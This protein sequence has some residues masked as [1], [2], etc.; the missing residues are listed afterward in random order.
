MRNL[1]T[2]FIRTYGC[3]MNELD[4][5]IMVGQLENR[6]LT[7][8][9]DE[10]NSDLLIYNTCSIRDLAER[11]IMGKLGKLEKLGRS[12]ENRAIIGVTGCM[13]MAKKE[14]L[15]RKAPH[16]DFVLGTNNLTDLNQV[17]DE[18]LEFGKHT[19][20]TDDQFEENLDYL[21]AKRDDPIKAYV[22]I[23][24]GC[25]KFCTYC[26][27]PYTRGQEVSRPP[28]SI[29]EECRILVQKGYKEITLLGQNVNSYGKDRPEWNCL[30][31]DLLYRLDKIKGLERVRFMTSHPI[32]ITLNL[33]QAIRDLPSLCEFV[34]FPIQAGSSRILK[35]MHRIYSKEQYLEKVSLLRELVPNVSLGTDIIVGFPT[36]TEEEFQET[37]DI[38]K[39]VRYSV[40]FLFTY[41]PRK[42]TP[43]FR[44]KDDIPLE[45]KEDRLHRLLALHNEISTEERLSMLGKEVEILVEGRN[46]D[47]S[48]LKAK[49]RCWKN[50]VFQGPNELIGTL[51][52]VKIHSYSN[53]TL[54]GELVK[55][56]RCQKT[57]LT[58]TIVGC[59]S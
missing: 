38:L 39:Q 41:S 30:F 31:H 57:P 9:E 53:Q 17:L 1:K 5:E 52:T 43:A 58:L 2:F 14:S 50:V 4:T 20:R 44:W 47:E 24:R 22:S 56:S 35:K 49:T 7:R 34:H 55:E 33:M 37:Y 3:Q 12:K 48:Q 15:F 45:V 26:V 23:I 46:K 27:V 8:T 28:D 54:I 32:D 11:K 21:I 18:V 36:E 59:C 25:D 42:G 19:I 40:A 6:G 10:E 16:I 51:Q 29:E 13:A